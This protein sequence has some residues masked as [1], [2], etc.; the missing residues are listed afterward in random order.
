MYLLLYSVIF[1]YHEVCGLS[2]IVSWVIFVEPKSIDSIVGVLGKE[3]YDHVA[4][5]ALFV[6]LN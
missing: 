5:G 2:Y 3:G 4:G 1:Y 6:T